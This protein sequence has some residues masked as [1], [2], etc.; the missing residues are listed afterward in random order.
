MKQQFFVGDK[1]YLADKIYKHSHV[2]W[3]D[4]IE[5]SK[6]IMGV[7]QD[8]VTYESGD[9][10]Y[11]VKFDNR[12][13]NCDAK[14]LTLVERAWQKNTGVMPVEDDVLVQVKQYGNNTPSLYW[15]RAGGFRWSKASV[16]SVSEWRLADSASN[17]EQPEA[18]PLPHV[19]LGET[20][21]Q[22]GEPYMK[23]WCDTCQGTGEIDETLGG[24]SFSSRDASCP[25]CDGKGWWERKGDIDQFGF[26]AAADE[27]VADAST[28]QEW[29]DKHYD[30]NYTLTQKD[31]EHGFVKIDP[32]RV[33]KQWRLGSKDESGVLF[34]ILKT[35]ARFGEKNSRER[36]V[37]ALYAQIKCLAEIEGV[38]L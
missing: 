20:F 25:D 31:I 29:T 17:E 16:I 14:W 18:I 33:S 28:N 8:I 7:V 5:K 6:G 32:Y 21:V 22:V 36:E 23:I 11:S 38:E 19:A 27:I 13:Y 10:G 34:H 24:E 35:V 3:I 4:E 2:F 26:G 1:V 9:I 15:G 37:K 30:N 12:Y